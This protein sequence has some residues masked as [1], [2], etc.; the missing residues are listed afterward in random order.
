[1]GAGTSFGPYLGLLADALTVPVLAA[2]LLGLGVAGV[3]AWRGGKAA[4][5]VLLADALTVPVLAAALLGLGVAGVRA[6]RGG[7]AA[8]VVMLAAVAPFVLVASSGHRALRFVAPVLPAA[9][10]LGALTLASI[11]ARGPRLG[12]TAA[13]LARSGVAALLVVRLFFVD[14]RLRAE[15]W[16]ERNVPRGATVDVITN[17]DGYAPRVPEGRNE[18]RLRTL[19]REMAPPERFEEAAARYLFEPSEWLV[20]TAAFYERFLQNPGQRP[21]RT[22]FFENLLNGKA[23]FSV[24]ARFREEGW[25]RPAA[26]EFL[27]PEIVVLRRDPTSR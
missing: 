15:R 12:L 18:R 4:V 10:W 16:M 26:D 25:R 20:L 2:A 17:H 21:E 6:W 11:R 19:S 13:V 14:S 23:G 1:V 7:K 8:I 27:D 22:R 24:A 9:A 5:V 3:R